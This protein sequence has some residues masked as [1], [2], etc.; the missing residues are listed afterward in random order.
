MTYLCILFI[1]PLYFLLRGQWL[2]FFVNSFFYGLAW[3]CVLSLFGI[4]IAPLFWMIALGH[5]SFCFRKEMRREFIEEQA[6]AM[7]TKMA[8]QMRKDLPPSASLPPSK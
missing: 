6:T 2:N 5:T 3:L 4:F 1:S 7:A 8:E